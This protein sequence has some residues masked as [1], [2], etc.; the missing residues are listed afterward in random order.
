MN[1]TCF[2]YV[3]DGA[4]LWLKLDPRTVSSSILGR[5][6]HMHVNTPI[7]LESLGGGILLNIRKYSARMNKLSV[8]QEEIENH[9]SL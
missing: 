2:V 4:M 1:W 6:S 9:L 5:I 8:R 3:N 7:C